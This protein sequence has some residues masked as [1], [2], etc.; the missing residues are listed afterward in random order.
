MP[1]KTVLVVDQESSIRVLLRQFLAAEGYTV[2]EAIDGAEALR[3]G[4]ERKEGIHLLLTD[5][6][7]PPMD[8]YELAGRLAPWQPQMKVLYMADYAK[9]RLD[10][11][12]FPGSG[13][14]VLQKPFSR[15][16]LVERVREL[17]NH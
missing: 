10:Q 11:R 5:L 4:T 17:L 13:S 14:T 12:E 1:S 2:L 15:E 6:V 8:G 9:D 3:I 16:A 7:M